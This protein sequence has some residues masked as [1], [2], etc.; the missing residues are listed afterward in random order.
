MK[1]VTFPVGNDV[2]EVYNSLW[3]GVET[4][5]FNGSVVSKHFNWFVGIHPFRVV[6]PDTNEIDHYRVEIRFSMSSS[7]CVTVD[8][9][10][11]DQCLLNQSGRHQQTTHLIGGNVRQDPNN[12]GVW[13][14]EK[15]TAAT[16][17][18]REEDLV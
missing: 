15:P 3:S 13:I 5:K 10:L 1:L 8:I 14:R 12:Y 7:T 9:F 11:N 17:L 2:I 4:V 16:K 6:N 18:Y